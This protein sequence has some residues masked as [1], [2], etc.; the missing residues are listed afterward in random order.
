LLKARGAAEPSPQFFFPKIE[1]LERA[2]F[3]RARFCARAVALKH[4]QTSGGHEKMEWRYLLHPYRAWRNA[5]TVE[6][7]VRRTGP[8][9][10][11]GRVA[12]EVLN[13]SSIV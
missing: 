7:G 2:R 8:V 4:P 3:F 11:M 1:M 5:L 13:R 10:L 6:D 12:A 9:L